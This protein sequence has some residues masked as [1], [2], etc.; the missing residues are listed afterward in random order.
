MSLFGLFSHFR[1]DLHV[2]CHPEK[3]YIGFCPKN[4]LG[5]QEKSFGQKV[6]VKFFR[7]DPYT[8]SNRIP[9]AFQN[10]SD[11]HVWCRRDTF[12]DHV[13]GPVW[14]SN[15]FPARALRA[16]GP[17]L[18][19]GA[20]T[21]GW[22][23]TLWRVYRFFFYKN[24]HNSGTKSK[25]IAPK[26]ENERSLR[27]LQ[28]GPP[29]YIENGP[30]LRVLIILEWHKPKTAKNRGEPQKMTPSS[31]TEFFLGVVPMGKL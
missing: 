7:L 22:G 20:L 4:S 28:M 1:S 11:L 29:S 26:V 30:K 13:W 23:K 8:L 10:W 3:F 17:L 25:K 15:V 6:N 18:A 21:L 16:L 24:G 12:F 27:G 2:G 19:E 14:D 9:R 5:R 31:E